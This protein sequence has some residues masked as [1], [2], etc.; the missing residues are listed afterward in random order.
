MEALSKRD[1]PI[2]KPI[3]VNRHC[4][5]ME[6]V[7]GHPLLVYDLL[8]VLYYIMYFILMILMRLFE[9]WLL[10]RSRL[11]DVENVEN[12]YDDL[13]NL[14]VRFAQ[15]GVIHGDFN[16]FNIMINNEEKPVVIDFPQM[17]S[18]SHPNAEMLVYLMYKD[19]YKARLI[20]RIFLTAFYLMNEWNVRVPILIYRLTNKQ[21]CQ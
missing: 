12:L 8:Y 6:L 19:E 2:P 7:N 1:F 14:I 9:I 10:F 15:H 18:V 17:M 20:L 3:D 5:I 4:V 21:N 11:Y 13:M 16:E